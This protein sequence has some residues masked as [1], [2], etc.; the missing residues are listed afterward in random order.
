M[1]QR[2]RDHQISDEPLA[3]QPRGL[4]GYDLGLL[5]GLGFAVVYGFA[6]EPIRLSFGLVAV[7]FVGGIIIGSAVTKGAWA[8]RPHITLRRLQLTA[9]L[10][11]VGAW[12]VG[13]FIAYVVSQA[14]IP[15]SSSG[16]LERISFGGFSDYFA[17]LFDSVRLAHAA[18]VSAAAFAAWRWA[19]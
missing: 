15:Q 1:T 4:R 19:R 9:A 11:A 12:I 13:V 18:A 7:G 3:S 17:G 5:A 2:P 14:L 10:I 16:L 8:G 6:S